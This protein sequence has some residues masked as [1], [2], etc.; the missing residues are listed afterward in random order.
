M[1]GM[2]TGT[3]AQQRVEEQLA[4]LLEKLEGQGVQQEK[5]ARELHAELQAEVAGASEGRTTP[6]R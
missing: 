3:R 2:S 5:L 4:A 1:S 6:A